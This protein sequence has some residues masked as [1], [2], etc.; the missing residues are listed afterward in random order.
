MTRR[1]A[2]GLAAAITMLVCPAAVAQAQQPG[3]SAPVAQGE[4]QPPAGQDPLIARLGLE[5]AHELA[6]GA[7]VTVGVVDSGVDWQHPK[8]TGALAG[9]GTQI[10]ES[11]TLSAGQP[12]DCAP[13]GTMVAGLIAARRGTDPRVYG[14]A[15]QSAIY[16]VRFASPVEN[17]R[18]DLLARGIRDAVDH[19]ARVLNLSFATPVDDP[20]IRAAVA[21]AVARGVVVVAAAGNEGRTQ[22]GQTWY[23]AAYDGV[24]AVA[25]VDERG[26]PVEESNAGD[27]VDI[28][29]PGVALTTTAPGGRYLTVG[30]TSFA[31]AVVSGTAAL[32]LQRYPKATAAEV[33]DRLTSTAVRIAGPRDRRVGAGIVDPYAALTAPGAAVPSAP[34]RPKQIEVA[35]LP[36]EDTALPPLAKT[37]L[38]WGGALLALA[39]IFAGVLVLRWARRSATGPARSAA[40]PPE[41]DLL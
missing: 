17:L 7:G 13:H 8:L 5:R 12:L 28:A 25:A 24:L 15:P 40:D 29:A 35:P 37:A 41:V 23:P 9:P 16:P 1:A 22:P 27:W 33:A 30:G 20:A 10:D 3:C 19:G 39:A 38:G 18:R 26:R 2:A 21:D 4:P 14:I 6:T 32:V 34:P 11:G 31:T 36:H